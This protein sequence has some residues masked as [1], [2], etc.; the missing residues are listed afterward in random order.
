[1]KTIIRVTVIMVMVVSALILCSSIYTLVQMR[2]GEK[3]DCTITFIGLPDG[4]VFGDFTDSD[5]VV[6]VNEP[7]YT[8]CIL[9]GYNHDVE[10]YYGKHAVFLYDK[11]SGKIV[12]YENVIRN[13]TVSI[14]ILLLSSVIVGKC[15]LRIKKG[16]IESTVSDLSAQSDL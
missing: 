6:H 3:V 13:I 4:T 15:S 2:N 8:S 10:P 16:D 7:L 11:H 14:A 1:M 12:N 9:Q 5:G